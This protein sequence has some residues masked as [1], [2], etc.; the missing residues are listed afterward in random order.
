LAELIEKDEYVRDLLVSMETITDIKLDEELLYIVRG[1]VET[2][3]VSH[4]GAITKN[5]I[6]PDWCTRKYWNEPT[7]LQ[8]LTSENPQTETYMLFGLHSALP[9]WRVVEFLTKKAG[10]SWKEAA[11]V[12]GYRTIQRDGVSVMGYLAD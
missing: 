11:Q 6:A 12:V 10:L 4:L 5:D 7:L 8:K 1:F 9:D 2:N 3:G